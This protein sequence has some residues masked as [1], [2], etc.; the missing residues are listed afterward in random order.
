M[1]KQRQQQREQWEL[2]PAKLRKS[3]L[4]WMLRIIGLAVLLGLMFYRLNGG[5]FY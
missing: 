1:A 4:R 3:M 5:R 2:Q